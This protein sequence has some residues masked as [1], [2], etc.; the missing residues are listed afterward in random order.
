MYSFLFWFRRRRS[1]H[2]SV[3]VLVRPVLV[4]YILYS[5][6]VSV[7]AALSVLVLP[8]LWSQRGCPVLRV[9][10]SGGMLCFEG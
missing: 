6:F 7:C 5:L 4:F 9:C 2:F 8:A 10:C 1:L 3:C